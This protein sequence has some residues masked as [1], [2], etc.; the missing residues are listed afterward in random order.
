MGLGREQSY[1][2][3]GLIFVASFNG[4]LS[5]SLAQ[6]PEVRWATQPRFGTSL[7]LLVEFPDVI[8]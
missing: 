6:W 7:V 8:F 5:M 3:Q 1:L 2:E 4:S